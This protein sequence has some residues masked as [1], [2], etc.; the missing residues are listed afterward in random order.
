MASSK[1]KTKFSDGKLFWMTVL[2]L[3]LSITS[4]VTLISYIQ[5]KNYN[6]RLEDETAMKYQI[7]GFQLKFC[8]ENDIK[9]CNQETVQEFNKKNHGSEE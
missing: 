2:A 6:D 3:L 1:P 8:Y 4:L 5:L 9:P 7:E